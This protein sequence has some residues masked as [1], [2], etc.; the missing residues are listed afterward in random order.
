MTFGQRST[1]K[2]QSQ[3][4]Q[5]Q[6]QRILVRV[7]SGF[8]S[9][10]T[11]R[12]VDLLTSSYDVSLTWT[13]ADV[14]VLAWLLTWSDDVIQHQQQ[15]SAR[16]RSVCVHRRVEDKL[17]TQVAHAKVVDHQILRPSRSVDEEA[18]MA[19]RVYGHDLEVRE[20]EAARGIFPKTTEARGTASG[21]RISWFFLRET[22]EHACVV[23]FF[24]RRL[25]LHRSVR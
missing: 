19:V 12:V 14:D 18:V 17:E 2:S 6:S 11:G 23:G 9:R 21:D 13:R 8:P 5:G 20:S 10:V 7:G 1:Q 3:L 15:I 16:G 24:R 22:E 25:D 4:V